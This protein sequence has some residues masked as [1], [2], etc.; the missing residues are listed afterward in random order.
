MMWAT[1]VRTQNPIYLMSEKDP[2]ALRQAFQH[3]LSQEDFYQSMNRFEVRATRQR[4]CVCVCVAGGSTSVCLRSAFG[5][6]LLTLS[7][8]SVAKSR[9]DALEAQSGTKML[10]VTV[11]SAANLPLFGASAPPPPPSPFLFLSLSLSDSCYWLLFAVACRR[12]S[13]TIL[14]SLCHAEPY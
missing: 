2:L 11:L 7:Q 14:P 6:F 12:Q 13:C 5:G 9:A 3:T 10:R 8:R 1:A 4:V